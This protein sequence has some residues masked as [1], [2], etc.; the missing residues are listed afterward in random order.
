MIKMSKFKAKVARNL[1]KLK[2]VSTILKKTLKM[3]TMIQETI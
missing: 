2:I 3:E 1:V